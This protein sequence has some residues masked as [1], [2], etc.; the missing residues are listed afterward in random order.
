MIRF[1]TTS[2]RNC[3]VNAWDITV[4]AFFDMSDMIR[5]VD[6]GGNLSDLLEGAEGE[7]E[8]GFRIAQLKGLLV[9][10]VMFYEPED[11]NEVVSGLSEIGSTFD[12]RQGT[13]ST[14]RNLLGWLEHGGDEKLFE[15]FED[16][17]HDMFVSEYLETDPHVDR[18][19]MLAL[20]TAHLDQFSFL[21]LLCVHEE[22]LEEYLPE[23]QRGR[24]TER[25]RSLTAV[26]EATGV[27][28]I[29]A[30]PG[31][32]ARGRPMKTTRNILGEPLNLPGQ[33]PLFILAT[34]ANGHPD[35][36]PHLSDEEEAIVI[37]VA[38]WCLARFGVTLGAYT[39][40]EPEP[41]PF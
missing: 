22:G 11:V 14:A 39:D 13:Y 27:E 19:A 41:E 4:E 33:L 34:S 3:E 7:T 25:I 21:R 18:G 28:L 20:M 32:E 40:E 38:D 29:A 36:M 23:D 2:E 35:L 24:M 16:P 31:A 5:Y 30:M 37:D 17:I 1:K 26:S 15:N 10:G 8:D 9:K 6:N 12:I